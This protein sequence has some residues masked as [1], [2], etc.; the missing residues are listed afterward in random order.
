MSNALQINQKNYT[1]SGPFH[2]S[3]DETLKI[4]EKCW[5]PNFILPEYCS[6]GLPAQAFK[7][8]T[9]NARVQIANCFCNT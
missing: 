4:P 5:P 7:M 9:T 2:R 1:L 8:V 6:S 3:K